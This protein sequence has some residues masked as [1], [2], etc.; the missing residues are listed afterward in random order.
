MIADI[1]FPALA[2]RSHNFLVFDAYDTAT[3]MGSVRAGNLNTGELVTIASGLDGYGVP[4]YNGDNTEVIYSAAADNATG[5]S[6]VAQAVSGRIRRGGFVTEP[7]AGGIGAVTAAALA[8]LVR[9]RQS[10]SSR[11]SR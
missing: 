5:Y 3:G 4:G 7:G 10:A 6:L 2:Q 9:A 8:A 11:A 1:G